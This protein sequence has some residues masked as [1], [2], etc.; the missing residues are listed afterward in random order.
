MSGHGKFLSKSKRQEAL[1]GY[2]FVLPDFAGL[3]IFVIIPILYAMFISF[4]DWDLIGPRT[5]IGLRN[6]HELWLDNQWWA[7]L[8]RTFQF[9]LIY[10]PS[11][12]ILSLFFAVLINFLK[13]KTISFV[14]TCFLMPF[15]ITSVI[16]ATLWM[17]LYN[18]K[19]GFLN[20]VL[21]MLGMPTLVFLGDIHQAMVS[22]IAVV[23]WINLGYNMILFLSAI[24]EIPIT[25]TEAAQLDGANHWQLFRHITLPSIQ[26]TSVF[27]LITSTIASFQILDQIMV[28]TRGGPSSATEVGV[29]YIYRQSFDLL[30]MGYASA[31]SIVLFLILLAFSL[32]QF[33]LT[34]AKQ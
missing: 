23:V 8:L 26:D 30:K 17:F 3:I 29:L 4:H 31:L 19:Q 14:R 34:S 11:L 18:E 12:L 15:A 10:V 21:K 32:L 22:V 25:Y 9:T 13:G 2:L 16:S 27:V 28:M 5:F 1:T 20:T 7:S 6:F 24:K 33:K